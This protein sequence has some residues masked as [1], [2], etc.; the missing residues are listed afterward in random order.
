VDFSYDGRFLASKSA[1]GTV[2]L[3]QTTDWREIAKLPET[4]S[5]FA[6]ASLAFHPSQP[7]LA[8]LGEK[9]KVIHIWDIDFSAWQ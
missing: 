4:H 9:D 2:R 8:A 6:F 1:D 5:T 3:W 7:V